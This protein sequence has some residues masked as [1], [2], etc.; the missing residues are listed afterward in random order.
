MRKQ[1]S[2]LRKPPY[3]M[4]TITSPS[5]STACIRGHTAIERDDHEERIWQPPVQ[6]DETY[7][8]AAQSADLRQS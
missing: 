2:R 5:D 8:P 4:A 6:Q 7:K 1:V 3:N